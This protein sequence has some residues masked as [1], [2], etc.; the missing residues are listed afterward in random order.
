MDQARRPGTRPSIRQDAPGIRMT[1]PVAASLSA[2]QIARRSGSSFLVSFAFLAPPRRRAL[3]TIYA[4]F[5]AIDDAV[6][7]I[8]DPAAARVQLDF[9][10]QELERVYTGTPT[11]G[12][13][14]S[15]AAAV[16]DYGVRREH[17]QEVLCGVEIDLGSPS[18]DDLEAMEGYCGKV[19]SAVGLACLSVMGVSGP[20]AERYADRLG[21][22]LQVTNILRDLRSDAEVGRVYVPR[23][24]LR[25]ESVDPQWLCGTGPPQ[26]YADGGPVHRIV[27]RL[28]E[29]AETRFAEAVEAL[30][31]DAL[32]P[33][34]SARIMAGI[35]GALL[36]KVLRRRGDLR[37]ADRLRVGNLHRILI[38]LR[39]W[40]GAGK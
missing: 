1:E 8:E 20:S 2:K 10:R 32:R 28:A 26:A 14:H 36:R 31:R 25:E 37:S 17:L 15:L 30:P 11:T 27:Q 18:F 38:A 3:T 39:A 4:F 24:W 19:A 12:L 5:R 13:G 33:L 29:V 6:D 21:K 7:E 35:Y 23:N 9:W 40:L 22:A 16:R 34:L